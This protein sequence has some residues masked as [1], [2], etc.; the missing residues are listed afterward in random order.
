MSIAELAARFWAQVDKRGPNDCWPW[1]GPRD[2]KGYGCAYTGRG[3]LSRLA[4]RFAW[5]LINGPVPAGLLICHHCDNPP[6]CNP[7]HL[8][9][10][11]ILDNARDMVAKGRGG[12]PKG[13]RNG[14][15]KLTREQVIT[16]LADQRGDTIVAR[17]LGVS[18]QTVNW[19]RKHGWG[20][21]EP[22]KIQRLHGNWK[23]GGRVRH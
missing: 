17:E 9:S 10:G 15:A 22:P 21:I 13:A 8:F 12:E 3:G 23:H 7:T 1:R 4:H 5:T 14:N 11:T 2:R 16:L 20:G 6:C 18:S 19:I